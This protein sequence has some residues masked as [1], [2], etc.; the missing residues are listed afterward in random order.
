VP[1]LP[2]QRVYRRV[3]RFGPDQEARPGRRLAIDPV[4][5]GE[6]FRAGIHD[7]DPARPRLVDVLAPLLAQVAPQRVFV[8]AQVDDPGCVRL[9]RVG[10]SPSRLPERGTERPF[11]IERAVQLDLGIDPQVRHAAFRALRTRCAS[12]VNASIELTFQ[13]RDRSAGRIGE[14][15]WHRPRASNEDLRADRAI[16]AWRLDQIRWAD[17]PL[18][19]LTAAQPDNWRYEPGSAASTNRSQLSGSGVVTTCAGVGSGRP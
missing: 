10:P 15:P 13:P 11:R 19:A 18:V 8:R 9:D 7:R 2:A 5:L 12:R 3:G 14:R 6:P 17:Q 4:E 1:D 16:R